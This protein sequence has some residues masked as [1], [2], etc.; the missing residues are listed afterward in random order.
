MRALHGL[1][2]SL[3]LLLAG[4]AFAA[5]QRDVEDC[6]WARGDSIAACTR[7]IRDK[8]E[9]TLRRRIAYEYRGLAYRDRG[10]FG[11]AI[12][13]YTAAIRLA[14]DSAT[15]YEDRGNAFRDRGE[16]DRAIADY[17][18]AIRLEPKI[19]WAYKS[20]GRAFFAKKE[21][22]EAAADFA[23]ATWL[24]LSDEESFYLLGVAEL[25]RGKRDAAIEAFREAFTLGSMD[26][27]AKLREL[28]A[29][30]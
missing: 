11:R 18:A 9:S 19:H 12:A 7:V 24:F 22:G 2:A 1:I 28:G 20:R 4:T 8:S 14:P 15:A 17:D 25:A 23:A 13:D 26:A 3:A 5:S 29:T 16:L 21:Y 27:R 6:I 30:P 10:D